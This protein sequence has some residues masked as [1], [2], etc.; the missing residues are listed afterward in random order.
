MARAN[1]ACLIYFGTVVVRPVG[2]SAD[3]L[4]FVV[5]E[6][7]LPKFVCHQPGCAASIRHSSSNPVI[8]AALPASIVCGFA[9]RFRLL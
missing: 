7:N 8:G 2:G 3:G 6:G 9:P 1:Y 4:V 5:P